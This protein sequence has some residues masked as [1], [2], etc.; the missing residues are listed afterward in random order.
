[1]GRGQCRSQ[2]CPIRGQA[3]RAD[4]KIFCLYIADDAAAVAEHAAAGGFPCDSVHT[5][6]TLIDPTTAE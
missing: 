2:A 4:D 1:M 6:R 3:L 5:V